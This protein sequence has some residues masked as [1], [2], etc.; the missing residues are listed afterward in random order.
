MMWGLKSRGVPWE[1]WRGVGRCRR[2]VVTAQDRVLGAYY[3]LSRNM[4][5]RMSSRCVIETLLQRVGVNRTHF[6]YLI[7]AARDDI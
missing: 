4:C 1:W 7:Q 3:N 2:E 6:L 5:A